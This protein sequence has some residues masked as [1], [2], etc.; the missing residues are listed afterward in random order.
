MFTLKDILIR[1]GGTLLGIALI[2]YVIHQGWAVIVGPRIELSGPG[3]GA[4]FTDP[5][6]HIFGVAT[7]TTYITVN[8]RPI[9][10]DEQGNFN[11]EFVLSPGDNIVSM[12]ARDRFGNEYTTMR[13]VMYN[14][15]SQFSEIDGSQNEVVEPQSIETDISPSENQ[16]SPPQVDSTP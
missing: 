4:V 2:A 12:Y 7:N 5:V 13:E 14:T 8:G 11:E 16:I 15:S 6:I 1:I 3:N 9:L 10:I